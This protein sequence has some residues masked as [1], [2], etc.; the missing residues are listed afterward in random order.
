[1][2]HLKWLSECFQTESKQNLWSEACRFYSLDSISDQILSKQKLNPIIALAYFLSSQQRSIITLEDNNDGI[3]RE[4]H[5][6]AAKSFK[7]YSD[8]Q[9]SQEEQYQEM[10][11]NTNKQFSK[12]VASVEEYEKESKSLTLKRLKKY[13]EDGVK[14]QARS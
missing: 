9:Q 4:I 12:I 7:K 2:R 14:A 6:I 1:M 8:I 13:A 11:K 10:T 5:S 3:L